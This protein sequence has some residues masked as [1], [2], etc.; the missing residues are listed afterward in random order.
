MDDRHAGPAARALWV[1]ALLI[2]TLLV[3]GAAYG[4]WWGGRFIALGCGPG[5]S[6]GF[7][8]LPVGGAGLLM[9]TA[10][11]AAAWRL[12]NY[13]RRKRSPRRRRPFVMLIVLPPGAAGLV[14]TLGQLR[15]SGVSIPYMLQGAIP[16]LAVLLLLIGVGWLVRAAMRPLP[17][18]GPG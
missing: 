15:A 9:A 10:G 17:T 7:P 8:F 13:A 12:L 5:R 6:D 2:A 1:A 4:A 16:N 11:A 14:G 3:V 18:R